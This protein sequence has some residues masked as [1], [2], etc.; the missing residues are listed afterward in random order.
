MKVI[1][2]FPPTTV[3][4]D[5]PS[6]PPVTQPLGLAYLGAYLEQEGHEVKILDSRGSRED[7]TR[8][9]THTR[10]GIPDEEILRRV[11]DFG[12]DVDRKSV[13]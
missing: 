6:V 3:Y 5:D 4:G 9:P 10:F 7:I 8:T 11:E 2:V 12:P 13:V 1:L